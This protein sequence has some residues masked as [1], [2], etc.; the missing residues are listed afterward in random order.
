MLDSETDSVWR[1]RERLLE[2]AR[3]VGLALIALAEEAA[4]R[5]PAEVRVT[6]ARQR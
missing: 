1:E 4:E 6:D 3:N 2:D 5:F